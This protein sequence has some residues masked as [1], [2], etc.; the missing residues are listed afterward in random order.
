MLAVQYSVPV[1][2]PDGGKKGDALVL[3]DRGVTEKLHNSHICKEHEAVK[4]III[5][6]A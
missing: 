4:K 2:A 3:E 1:S 5:T 6:Y